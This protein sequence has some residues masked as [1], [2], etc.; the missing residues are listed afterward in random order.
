MPD[1]NKDYWM[2]DN[3]IL[4][5]DGWKYGVAKDGST[6]CVGPVSG[7]T[8]TTPVAEKVVQKV[9]DEGLQG[10]KEEQVV[11]AQP[12][13]VSCQPPD[14]KKVIGRPTLDLPVGRI[15]TLN[16]QGISVTKIIEQLQADNIKVSRR[17]VYNV[18]AGQKVLL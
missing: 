9:K 4:V 15:C 1:Q 5:C 17:T 14:G 2:K 12:E 10:E 11:F 16:S 7:A 13:T 8:Q 18:I 6:I 3:N